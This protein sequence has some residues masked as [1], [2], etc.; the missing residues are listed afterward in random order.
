MPKSIDTVNEYMDMDMD[1]CIEEG[2]GGG[3]GRVIEASRCH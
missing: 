3:G 1:G 2:G